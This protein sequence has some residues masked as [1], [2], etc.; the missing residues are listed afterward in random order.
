MPVIINRNQVESGSTTNSKGIES[1]PA[2]I[3]ENKLTVCECSGKW[4]ASKKISNDTAKDA[5][6]APHAISPESDLLIFFPKKPLIKNPIKGKRGTK[7]TNLII[8]IL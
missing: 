7:P 3:H 1:E 5:K 6:I 4:R 2:F 8:L